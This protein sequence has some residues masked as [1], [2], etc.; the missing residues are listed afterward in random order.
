[1]KKNFLKS[2]KGLFKT[3]KNELRE[4]TKMLRYYGISGNVVRNS[5]NNELIPNTGLTGRP[6]YQKGKVYGNQVQYELK[7]KLQK[8]RQL[9]NIK[10]NLFNVPPSITFISYKCPG[11]DSTSSACRLFNI[12]KISKE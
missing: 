9:N 4:R 7:D 6:K 3:G 2:F 1:M 10:K 5:L 12:L 11:I 8:I